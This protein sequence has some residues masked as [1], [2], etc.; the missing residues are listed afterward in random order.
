[1]Y[2]LHKTILPINHLNLIIGGYTADHPV[3]KIFWR[4]VESFTDEEKR[5]LLKF[6]TSCSRPPLLGFKVYI[7]LT[8]WQ[9]F[10]NTTGYDT[11]FSCLYDYNLRRMF[12]CD[13]RNSF[14]V[15]ICMYNEYSFK[16][17]DEMFCCFLF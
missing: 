1:M 2:F 8:S 14:D 13:Y 9:V 3:I 4:V 6:V 17:F 12:L 10:V 16:I 11:S 7:F 15:C 5:K